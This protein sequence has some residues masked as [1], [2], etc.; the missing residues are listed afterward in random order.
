MTTLTVMM[1]GGEMFLLQGVV[2][3]V[4][5]QLWSDTFDGTVYFLEE[6]KKVDLDVDPTQKRELS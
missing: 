5:Q 6:H 3:G 4:G 2:D 1:G